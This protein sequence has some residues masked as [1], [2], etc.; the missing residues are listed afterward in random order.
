MEDCNPVSIPMETRSKLSKDDVSPSV[1]Q[2]IYRSMVESLLFVTATRLDIMQAVGYV[3]R[4]QASPK[5][6]HVKVVKRIF[7]YLKSTT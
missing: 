4:C 3:A 2:T 7:K 6:T 1:D 5:Q